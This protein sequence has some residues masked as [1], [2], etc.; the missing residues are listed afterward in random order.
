MIERRIYKQNNMNK[1]AGIG[2]T[3]VILVLIVFIIILLVLLLLC[4]KGNIPQI[5]ENIMNITSYFR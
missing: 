3:I 4:S 1:K 2:E 5:I